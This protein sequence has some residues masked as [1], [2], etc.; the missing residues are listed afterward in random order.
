MPLPKKIKIHGLNYDV[1]YFTESATVDK[2]GLE[3]L[4]GQVSHWEHEIRVVKGP[5]YSREYT[6]NVLLHEIVHALFIGMGYEDGGAEDVVNRLGRGLFAVLTDNG[7]MP[8][9]WSK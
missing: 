6:I 5:G 1:K 8:P 9:G 4:H 3:T 7:W 2:Q